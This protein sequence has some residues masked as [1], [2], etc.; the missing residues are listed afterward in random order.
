[1]NEILTRCHYDN[2]EIIVFENETLIIIDSDQPDFI[3]QMKQFLALRGHVLTPVRNVLS[4]NSRKFNVLNLL[5]KQFKEWE[6][7]KEFYQRRNG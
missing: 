4:V 5:D 7:A 3:A 2:T 6:E 1:M